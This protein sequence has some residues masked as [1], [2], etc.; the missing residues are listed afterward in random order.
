VSFFLF[1][2]SIKDLKDKAILLSESE[3]LSEITD[4]RLLL[5]SCLSLGIHIYDIYYMFFLSWTAP[6]SFE[7]YRLAFGGDAP[8]AFDNLSS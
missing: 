7:F 3:D 1:L 8:K 6:S 2:K 4:D 5:L